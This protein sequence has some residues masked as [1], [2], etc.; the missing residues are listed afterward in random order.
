[1]RGMVFTPWGVSYTE[2][3]DGVDGESMLI[4]TAAARASRLSASRR[5]YCSINR[6]ATRA[7]AEKVFKGI[8]DGRSGNAR[9][10]RQSFSP[11]NRR[12]AFV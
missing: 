3:I 6:H 11:Y 2:R 4:S 8:K 10:I 1:M 9:R 5:R 12:R 7:V